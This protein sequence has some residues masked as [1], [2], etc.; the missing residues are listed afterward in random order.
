MI[1]GV[2]VDSRDKV[3]GLDLSMYR[4]EGYNLEA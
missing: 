1:P 4:E 2:R 3:T